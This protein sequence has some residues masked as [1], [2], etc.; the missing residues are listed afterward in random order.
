MAQARVGER[1]DR[2]PA[3]GGIVG[4]ARGGR[5]IDMNRAADHPREF[6]MHDGR[7]AVDPCARD[8]RLAAVAARAG[9]RD[10]RDVE[11]ARQRVAQRIERAL[12]REH[13][14]ERAAGFVARPVRLRI[15]AAAPRRHDDQHARNAHALRRGLRRDR[16]ERPVQCLRMR[17]VHDEER[18]GILR[19]AL[20]E[21]RGIAARVAD[22]QNRIGDRRPR[23][24][25]PRRGFAVRLHGRPVV[26]V[27]PLIDVALLLVFGRLAGDGPLR[28]RVD[29]ARDLVERMRH[30]RHDVAARVAVER[31]PVDLDAV[32]PAL[33]GQRVEQRRLAA[34][35]HRRQAGHLGERHPRERV[36]D[37]LARPRLDPRT[38]R[39]ERSQR[40]EA[41]VEANRTTQVI[42]PIAGCREALRQVGA[43]VEIGDDR[44]ARR[45]QR[46]AVERRREFAAARL[47]Q[48]R[49]KRVRRLQSHRCEPGTGEPRGERVDRLLGA[50]DDARRIAVDRAQ[51]QRF[52][53]ERRDP[54][55]FGQHR[56]HRAARRAAHDA[57]ADR[58]DRD[59][60][61][62]IEHAG[63]RRRD[64]FAEAVAD[65]RRD[66]QSHR[67]Q[68][69]AQRIF[70]REQVGLQNRRVANARIVRIQ[71]LARVRAAFAHEAVRAIVERRAELPAARVERAAHARILRALAG[72]QQRRM[73]VTP[74]AR[75]RDAAPP[76]RGVEHERPL[77]RQMP[78]E[79]LRCVA[80]VTARQ[81]LPRERIVVLRI[82]RVERVRRLRGHQQRPRVDAPRQIPLRRLLE[83]HVRVA[84]ADAERADRRASRLAFGV[85][86]GLGRARNIERRAVERQIRVRAL[87]PGERRLD[88]V[89]HAQRRLE[90]AREPR[91][92]VRV[93]DVRLRR[94][95]R[96]AR[97]RAHA[98]IAAVCVLQRLNLDRIAERRARA[99]RL[100]IADR[101]R[102]DPAAFVRTPDRLA[103]PGDARRRV[104]RFALAV[105][106]DRRAANDADD[107]VSV[108][109]R[110]GQRLQ[111]EHHRAVREHGAGRARVERPA[112]AVLREHAVALVQ[113]AFRL[114]RADGGRADERHPA[115]PGENRDP[116]VVQRH[117]RGRAPRLDRH[118]RAVQIELVRDAGGRA[119]AA[120]AEH[121][122]RQR[123]PAR[124]LGAQVVQQIVREADRRVDADVS[125]RRADL[126]EQL[127]REREQH[128][129]L[130]VDRLR[131]PERVAEEAVIEPVDVGEHARALHVI[132]QARERGIDARREQLRVGQRIDAIPA[133][134][135]VLPERIDG[136]GAG[137]PQ[138]GS[139]QCYLF[140]VFLKI[141]WSGR[142]ARPRR[143]ASA[144]RPAG[145]GRI[146]TRCRRQ[147][148]RRTRPCC[149]RR[150]LACACGN[151]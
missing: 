41:V 30:E 38:E 123:D 53:E 76:A 120:V 138:S 83:N 103:L 43:P 80:R 150:R 4:L 24:R 145:C 112:N 137:Q 15:R 3:R 23:R 7:E 73:R 89:L 90:H 40:R 84:A 92:D 116:R 151:R 106:V 64:V 22:Q 5:G 18:F 20:G 67:Q 136:I 117:Q 98:G 32:R 127:M 119:I 139:N 82:E 135:N 101:L 52:V 102:P 125:A 36:G 69:R 114:R 68:R 77:L 14:I 86:P 45:A 51:R 56:E 25:M 149:I 59:R 146:R 65:R 37:R 128:A 132:G 142:T 2:A 99:V 144:R 17:A 57:G 31:R 147:V 60:V 16:R 113:I 81:R 54:R 9:Q 104:A 26:F 121:H 6:L 44:K 10:Q 126:L 133:G 129:L 19:D 141:A 78:T 131:F 70:E 134:Q 110:G 140:H 93:P 108:A 42:D 39:H 29:P 107:V 143:P 47:H 148:P 105:V 79:Q 49:M 27:E 61:G 62:Q 109:L 74:V 8:R 11:L 118:R 71:Q 88:R 97:A 95:E 111:R 48:V 46:H 58:D 75:R 13:R 12:H 28:R 63:E 33:R 34:G 130:R 96:A 115:L 94:A 87:E 55:F 124:R 72:K 85:R 35:Q 66:G 1:I 100:D 122:V 21:P 50:A 91:R